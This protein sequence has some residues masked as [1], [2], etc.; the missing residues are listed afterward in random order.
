MKKTIVFLSAFILAVGGAIVL[1]V[2]WKNSLPKASVTEIKK[3]NY[4]DYVSA[5][6]EVYVNN[7]KAVVTVLVSENNIYKVKEGQKAV[8][9]GNAF[10]DISYEADVVSISGTAVKGINGAVFVPVE[11]KIMNIDENIRSGYSVKAK[12]LSDDEKEISVIPYEVIKADENGNEFVYVW[13]SGVAVRKDI[14]TGLETKDGVE[15]T[16]GI[17]EN[18]CIIYGDDEIENGKYIVIGEE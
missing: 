3:I 5:S 2:M 18:D 14:E 9:T 4:N 7:D 8:I 6:G 13:N 15:I 16:D 17:D 12:I 11:M 1:P 10:P